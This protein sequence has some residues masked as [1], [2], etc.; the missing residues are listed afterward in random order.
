[1]ADRDGV[2][3]RRF[4]AFL[5]G[6]G[7]NSPMETEQHIST[8]ACST[9]DAVIPFTPV[10]NAFEN[11]H[12]SLTIYTTGDALSA[13]D[14]VARQSPVAP[15]NTVAEQVVKQLEHYFD[16]PQWR[17][18]LPLQLRGTDFQRRLWSALCDVPAGSTNTYG[19]LA[20]LLQSGAQAVGQACRRN[21]VPIVAPC[22]RIVSLSGLGGYDGATGGEKLQIKQ[23]LLAH[24]GIFDGR[25]G[26]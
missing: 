24:E 1:L 11:A 26:G 3:Q 5:V 15:R 6:M 23:A 16:D 2:S 25:S 8:A 18:D 21:P 13:I 9:A 14:F 7:Q 19:Q 22:H 4:A 20:H 12:L 10:N 17:F